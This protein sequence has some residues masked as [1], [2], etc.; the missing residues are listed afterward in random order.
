MSKRLLLFGRYRK[1]LI[2]NVPHRFTVYSIALQ[3][4]SRGSIFASSCADGKLRLFDIRLN[5]ADPVIQ[6][7]SRS[8]ALHSAMFSPKEPALVA[9]AGLGD[10]TQLHDMR[11]PTRCLQ[12]FPSQEGTIEVRFNSKGTRLLCLETNRPP[13]LYDLPTRR[14]WEADQGKM[15][16]VMAEKHNRGH[17]LMDAACFAGRDDDLVIAG[18]EDHGIY[19]WRIPDGPILP[20]L[21]DDEEN[22]PFIAIRGHRSIVNQVRYNDHFSTLASCSNNKE[23][24][25]WTPFSLPHSIHFKERRRND[26]D[27]TFNPD[28]YLS[29]LSISDSD[30][31]EDDDNDNE[32]SIVSSIS[33]SS[34]SSGDWDTDEQKIED[35]LMSSSSM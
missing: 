29:S 16:L 32:G 35:A 3:P 24:K 17:C 2:N 8:G 9:A 25:F 27:S 18:S 11:L 12:F 1:Q 14:H 26:S 23:I 10:G 22:E 13:V 20:P 6:T 21:I 15:Q 30:W 33:T 5:S 19:I 4:E 7:A 28:D 31:N 34:N